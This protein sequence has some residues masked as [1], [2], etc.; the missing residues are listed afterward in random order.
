[1][2][3]PAKF[4]RDRAIE[5]VMHEVWRHGFDRASVKA[6]SEK[7]GITRSSFYNAFGNR[8]SLFAAALERYFAQAEDRPLHEAGPGTPVRPMITN[9]FRQICHSRAKD[10]EARGCM[11]VNGVAE[12]C[13][14]E[15]A[16]GAMLAEALL[17]SLENIRHLLQRAR[18]Q[19][20]ISADVSI[21]ALALAVQNLMVGLSVTAKVVR[22]EALLWHGTALTLKG[23]GL[24]E[25]TDDAKL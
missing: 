7:L 18:A 11:V 23:L 25:E 22:D 12:L 1:M 19:G 16:L 17:G 20:E 2:G 8:E 13:P 3:R 14:A 5:T 10:P 15:D 6:L 21:P 4:D 24:Y 9:V